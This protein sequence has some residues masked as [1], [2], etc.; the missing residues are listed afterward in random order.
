[1][2]R[3]AYALAATLNAPR[4]GSLAVI[5]AGWAGL[6]AAVRAVEQGHRV[7]LYEMAAQPGGRAREVMH[8]DVP[9]DNGQHILI[10]AYRETLALM[11]TVGADPDALFERRPLAL[12]D[13]Q[14]RGFAMPAG[15]PLR[16]VLRAV[17]NLRWSWRERAALMAAALRWR[18]AGFNAP[19]GQTV[20]VLTRDLPKRVRTELIDPLC[21]A[22][23]NTPAD[24]ASAQVFLTVLRDALLGGTGSADLLLPRSTLSAL[25]P[26]PARR[27]L[28][29]HG[30]K[31]QWG[32]RVQQIEPGWRVDGASFDAVVLAC[33]ATEAARLAA[34]FAP[35][36]ASQAAAFDYEPIVTV[37]LHSARSRWSH[38]MVMLASDETRPAQF[39]FDLGALDA[40]GRR[41]GLFAFVVS[42]ARGWVDRGVQDCAEAVLHQACD[43]FP[44]DAWVAAPTV[45][46]TLTEKRAT[47]LCVPDLQRPSAWL[48]HGLAAA[49]D[50]VRGPYPAT[51]EGA[52]RSGIASLR[53]LQQSTA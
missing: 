37:Y 8:G 42:G 46:R 48:A 39:A 35:A 5:G 15:S 7:T 4:V 10:G 26:E 31:L 22:A 43:A 36:W 6:A 2:D 28:A 40:A 12:L 1:V 38:P 44:A 16:A 53:A 20:A 45:V 23:L 14:G 3:D 9:L 11:R 27:W 13:P 33:S 18:L 47:F 24:L 32:H 50:Y 19:Q 52:V 30:A 17:L 34:P 21:V 29:A 51:L 25:L 41:N 49:G